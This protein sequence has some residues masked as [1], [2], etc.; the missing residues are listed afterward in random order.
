MPEGEFPLG[1]PQ[2]G[3]K[4]GGDSGKTEECEHYTPPHLLLS[5]KP[6]V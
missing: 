5:A 4:G 6:G 2:E 1:Y 3:R